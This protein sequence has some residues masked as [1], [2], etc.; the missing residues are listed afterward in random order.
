MLTHAIRPTGEKDSTGDGQVNF[1]V[2]PDEG[3]T[4]ES[5]KAEG[6]FKNIKDICDSAGIPDT[7]RI[8]KIESALTV[9]VNVTEEVSTTDTADDANTDIGTETDAFLSNTIDFV[10]IS[11]I[12]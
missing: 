12:R 6:T 5:V 10:S 2:I 7:Y 4:V 3:Y 9:I 1:T 11:R 8:T